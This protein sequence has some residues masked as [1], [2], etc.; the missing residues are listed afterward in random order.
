M[1]SRRSFVEA[2]LA[3]A[4]VSCGRKPTRLDGYAYVA[5][6][7]GNTIAVVDL[8]AFAVTRYIRLD[9][10]P[11]AIISHPKR[12]FI[13]VLTPKTG[14]LHE[15]D[16]NS[17]AVVRKV[18]AAR[19]ALSMRMDP[20][21]T[22]I[23]V[24]SSEARK[25]VR[26]PFDSFRP[27]AQIQLPYE[28]VDFDLSERSLAGISYGPAGSIGLVHLPTQTL[29]RPVRVADRVGSVAFRSGGDALLV[30]NTSGRMLSLYQAPGS[31]I[32]TH[33]PLAV[34]PD[35]FCFNQDGGQMFI[36]GEG[37]DAVVIVYPHHVP[38][39]AET[40]LAGRA[41]GA[42]GVSTDFLF[43]ANPMTG[44]VAV[45]KIDSRKLVA[46]AAVGSEPSFIAVT[47][48]N[49]FALVLN[50]KSGDM[51]VIRIDAVKP[52]RNRSVGLFTMIPVGS[53][54]VCAVI[55]S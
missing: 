25:L 21:A 53:R 35:Y 47:R 11:T 9:A 5:N 4:A 43:V 40:A 42:M 39:V 7:D 36:T 18:E 13:Y 6:Q 23:W 49:R 44:D 22:A 33:L 34:R 54:P 55:R 31:R 41:P 15:I 51:A 45:F 46:I 8:A 26:V 12:P 2:S 50:R 52:S 27:E 3:G 38:Q 20:A 14:T 24:L 29:E 30:A 10:S 19:S 16:V 48:N 17:L 1:I 28:P 32:I 37:M